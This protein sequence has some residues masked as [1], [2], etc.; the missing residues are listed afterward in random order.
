MN[1]NKSFLS[2]FVSSIWSQQKRNMINTG[3]GQWLQPC[4]LQLF[5][6]DLQ[7][8]DRRDRSHK[9]EKP[10]KTVT[11]VLGP[12]CA[13]SGD[14]NTERNRDSKNCIHDIQR[15]RRT[16]PGSRLETTYVSLRQGISLC[17]EDVSEAEFKTKEQNCLTRKLQESIELSM[18]YGP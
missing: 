4:C 7:E 9:P 18:W 2:Y 8:E 11:T 12:F 15:G 13:S 5:G 17:P 6:T 14:Q 10:Q 1:Q 16:R 3:T